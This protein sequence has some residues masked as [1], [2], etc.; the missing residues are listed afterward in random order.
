MFFSDTTSSSELENLKNLY[1]N[2]QYKTMKGK[3]SFI[4]TRQDVKDALD[5]FQIGNTK[6]LRVRPNKSVPM[7]GCWKGKVIDY[8]ELENKTIELH[9]INFPQQAYTPL[10]LGDEKIDQPC[11][12]SVIVNE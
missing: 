6:V 2:R 9:F 4:H 11:I 12:L 1:A 7:Y 8:S 3:I 5:V 10:R